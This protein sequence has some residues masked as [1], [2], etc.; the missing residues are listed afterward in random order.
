MMEGIL[1]NE[2]IYRKKMG[3]PTP[4]AHMFSGNLREYVG[5]LLLSNNS[6]IQRYVKKDKVEKIFQEHVGGKFDHHR[7]LWQLTVLE[8]WLQQNL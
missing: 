2:I 6:K 7:L 1:P 5:D 3:F 8:E 4:L